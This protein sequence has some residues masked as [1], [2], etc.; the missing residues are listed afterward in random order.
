MFTEEHIFVPVMEIK[1]DPLFYFLLYLS[2]VL[3]ARASYFFIASTC[4]ISLLPEIFFKL[5]NVSESPHPPKSTSDSNS[6]KYKTIDSSAT[7]NKQKS[8]SSCKMKKSRNSELTLSVKQGKS[9]PNS[10]V[11]DSFSI[12]QRLRG[13]IAATVC[14]SCLVKQPHNAPVSAAM[15]LAEQMMTPVLIQAGCQPVYSLLY[16]V[17]MG[18]VFFFLQVN[19]LVLCIYQMM[20]CA[21]SISIPNNCFK[22]LFN[23]YW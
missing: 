10:D 3:E 5:D 19:F 7:V 9:K 8:S 17:W 11:Y 22:I 4:L 1:R 14:F 16:S 12:H 15:S 18:Q 23:I 2:G 20:Q 6:A 13:I 21:V